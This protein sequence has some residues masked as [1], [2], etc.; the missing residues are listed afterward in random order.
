[1]PPRRKGSLKPRSQPYLLGKPQPRVARQT[2]SKGLP[3]C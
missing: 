3:K 2:L 1:M